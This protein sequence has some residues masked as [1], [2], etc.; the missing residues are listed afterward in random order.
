M[1]RRG[2]LKKFGGRKVSRQTKKAAR[3]LMRGKSKVGGTYSRQT[4]GMSRKQKKREAI[5]TIYDMKRMGKFGDD[6][7][8]QLGGEYL[9]DL[10][11]ERESYKHG[12][13]IQHD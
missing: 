1:F 13:I 3:K 2:G 11:V 10:G 7:Q 12:G 4:Q 8:T 9:A 5:A 6:H